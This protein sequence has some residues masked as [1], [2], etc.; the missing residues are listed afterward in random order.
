LFRLITALAVMI[1]GQAC[2]SSSSSSSDDSRDMAKYSA[3][4]DPVTPRFKPDVQKFGYDCTNNAVISKSFRSASQRSFKIDYEE[5]KGMEFL[6]PE[7]GVTYPVRV[8]FE[9]VRDTTGRVW[10]FSLDSDTAIS[11]FYTLKLPTAAISILPQEKRSTMTLGITVAG[12]NLIRMKDEMMEIDDSASS[13]TI[14]TVLSGFIAQTPI[15]TTRT[16]PLTYPLETPASDEDTISIVKLLYSDPEDDIATS[17]EISELNQVEVAEA[18]QC[19]STGECQVGIRG[20]LNYFGSAGFKYAVTA[21]GQSS[22][23][24]SVGFTINPIDDAPQAEELNI[25]RID[26]GSTHTVALAYTDAEDGKASTCAITAPAHIDQTS[27]VCTA[28]GECSAS[29][30]STSGFSGETSFTY[31]ITVND[32]TSESSTVYLLVDNYPVVSNF[33]STSILEDASGTINLSYTDANGHLATACELSELQNLSVNAA[34]SCDTLGI[35]SVA[36]QGTAHFNGNASLKYRVTAN[37]LTSEYAQAT[38]PISAV[39][40]APTIND[41]SFSL[42][43]DGSASFQIAYEDIESD[44]ATACQ[45]SNLSNLSQI[46]SCQCSTGVCTW[47]AAATPANYFGAASFDI[48][49]TASGLTSTTRNLTVNINAVDDAPVSSDVAAANINED[50]NSG[51]INLSYVDVEN[52]A[53]ATCA[54]SNLSNLTVVGSCACVAGLCQLRVRGT[55]DYNGPASLDYTVTANGLTSNSS[56]IDIDIDPVDDAPVGTLITPTITISEDVESDFIALTYTD[57]ESN[58]ATSC[59]VSNESNVLETTNCACS[60]GNCTVKVTSTPNY[61]GSASFDYTVTANGLTSVSKTVSFTIAAVDDAPVANDIGPISMNEDIASQIT[62]DY[63]DVENHSA[64]ACAVT[65]SNANITVTTAC[66]CTAG[67]CRVGITGALNYNGAA[68]FSYTVTANT[69]TSNSATA[70]LSIAAVDDAPVAV[71]ITVPDFD[72]EAV[73]TISLAINTAYTDVESDPATSCSI[74]ATS[75]VSVSTA[76]SCSTGTCT[77]GVTGSLNQY[78]AA[79]VSFRVQSNGLQSNTAIASFN[80]TQVNDLPVATNTSANMSED[81]A[82]LI[83]LTYQDVDD[84]IATSCSVSN[85]DSNIN[86]STACAC[87][88]F[89]VCKVGILGDMNYFGAATFDFNVTTG[90]DTSNNA[91]ASLNIQAVDDAP[92]AAD[93]TPAAFNEDTASNITLSYSD[94]ESHAA[95]SCAIIATTNITVD[96]AC[97][98]VTGVCT[99]G[100][101]GT[102]N[103]FGAASF[104]YRVTANSLQSNTATAS[105]TIN[106]VDDAPVANNFT[107]SGTILEETEG[108]VTLQ[109]TDVESDQA[110]T[111][112]VTPS[113]N[114]TVSSACSCTSGVCTVGVTGVSN[115]FGSTNFTFSVVANGLSS[116]T[117]TATLTITNVNDP[118]T[119]AASNSA[120]D[121][122][123]D[124]LSSGIPLP[125]QD[126][127]ND[128]ATSCTI[129]NQ[130]NLLT[131]STCTCTSGTCLAYIQ[132]TSNYN[133]PAS[134]DFVVT[135]NSQTSNS[136]NMTLTITAVD[137]PPVTTSFT[138]TAINE[139]TTSDWIS[140]SLASQYTDVESDQ[141]TTCSISDLTNLT[142]TDACTCS[143]G[144]C[145]V[146]VRGTT[147]FNGSASF[148]YVVRSNGLNSNSS[149]VSITVNAVDDAPDAQ[150]VTWKEIN[151]DTDGVVTLSYTDVESDKATTCAVVGAPANLTILPAG[152]SCNGAGVCTVAV[153][154]S[155]QHWFGETSLD[156]KVLTGAV[157]SD[158]ETA[159]VRIL[160]VDDAPVANNFTATAFDEDVATFITLDYTDV[161][162]DQATS[163]TVSSP[164]NISIVTNCACATGICT[165]RVQGSPTHYNGSAS[166]NFTVYANG[167]TSNQGIATLSITPVNDNP[168]LNTNSALSVIYQST[169]NVINLAKLNSSDV[170]DTDANIIYT[171]TAATS[172]GTLYKNGVSVGTG[173]SFTDADVGAGLVTYSHTAGDYSSDS[174]NFTVKDDDT[175]YAPTATVATPATFTI[176]I[177]PAQVNCADYVTETSYQIGGDGSSTSP[178]QIC[179]AVQI[180]AIADACTTGQNAACSKHFV[181]RGDI[182]MQDIG[183]FVM[184]GAS[185]NKYVGTFDGNGKTISNLNIGSGSTDYVGLFGYTGSAAQVKNLIVKG[186]VTGQAYVG[187]VVAYNEG[188]LNKVGFDGTVSSSATGV[189][190]GGLVGFH[191][192]TIQNSFARGTVSASSGSN[193][194]GGL[195][196]RVAIGTVSTSYSTA[197]VTSSSQAGG[198]VGTS[199]SGTYS[200][201]YWDT[202]TSGRNNAYDG[203]AGSVS[204]ISG[205]TTSNMKLKANYCANFDFVSTWRGYDYVSVPRLSFE[206]TLLDCAAAG[207]HFYDTDSNGSYDACYYPAYSGCESGNG[208]GVDSNLDGALDACVFIGSDNA[209]CASTCSAN[210]N[211]KTYSA[212]QTAK[213]AA[214]TTLCEFAVERLIGG[215]GPPASYNYWNYSETTFYSGTNLMND[216]GCMRS[217]NP[218]YRFFDEDEFIVT[219]TGSSGISQSAPASNHPFI[220]PA[221]GGHIRRVCGCVN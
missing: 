3:C 62:L 9:L 107:H 213:V 206:A 134:F 165:V 118:P 113:S 45:V 220:Q 172:K 209:T 127:D 71:N 70:T 102:L 208:M 88:G 170:D 77:V 173:N 18:C 39:D 82:S 46:V 74:T 215:S 167:K 69:L 143:S 201:N 96:T 120:S 28:D 93:I 128:L 144:T 12:G 23:S 121:V 149:T 219:S 8:E 101:K 184:I 221:N 207:S 160:P 50:T 202:T 37:Q 193:Q 174:F 20:I 116:N 56:T 198:L 187:G 205:L 30:R 40:D 89:G 154:G 158:I 175:A 53:A 151:E 97:A 122:A 54:T 61:F 79:S 188:T 163:C 87:D 190:V 17:C 216:I 137:D 169:G 1:A 99:V 112:S 147:N 186:T 14:H 103:Y 183:G 90:S 57:V 135:A 110:T 148:K 161:E 51:L 83:T 15:K 47:T 26:E 156:F 104:T 146:K 58:Q 73:S 98:C 34:C 13:M 80:L 164:T 176:N 131:P 24:S 194:A 66:A 41:Q 55:Q 2:N 191:S 177:I 115:F 185:G 6:L 52:H 94:V 38:V 33:T 155:P 114:I 152:C 68:E 72:E 4:T 136:G 138:S 48:N 81:V 178:Y 180:D 162:S 212:T 16:P 192:G 133:G 139:D 75:K 145:Q 130:S 11:D 119:V 25:G 100:V 108:I 91:T 123:E 117:A 49:L 36:V 142:V 60:G 218:D 203:T 95:T 59:S 126:V 141:A 64:T 32:L 85:L 129:S 31:T 181:L 150:D 84:Q 199:N 76:C 195:V 179:N 63:D 200:C 44:S 124:T 211:L 78:G 166:F 7:T 182:D 217:D 197:T 27:C 189:Y 125:Y 157:E 29:F 214:K 22:E 10:G 67:V 105:L 140:F 210:N 153:R 109:Y 204:E 35:C 19:S 21:D 171:L 196:G 106:P 65:P 159:L 5:F 92:V 132:G 168:A 42:T 86:V 43:E 111:C